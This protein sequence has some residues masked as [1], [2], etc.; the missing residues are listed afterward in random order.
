MERRITPPREFED[1]LDRLTEGRDKVFETKQKALMFAAALGKRLDRRMPMDRKGEG[2]RFDIFER[3]LDD[4]FIN[5]L[6]V[7][8][9]G[10]LRVL[11]EERVDERAA[12]FE[13]YA[14]GGLHELKRLCFEKAGDP[15][16]N[17]VHEIARMREE[18]VDLP[19]LDP[20]VLRNLTG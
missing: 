15:V 16:Q 14:H 9:T 17:L 5:A 1:M 11:G 3:S 12:I 19:G 20:S 7:S 18:N 2:I 8:E 13:E 10:D 6:A 4:G